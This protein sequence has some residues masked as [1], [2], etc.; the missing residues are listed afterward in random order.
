MDNAELMNLLPF[1]FQKIKDFI[2]LMETEETELNLLNL[3]RQRVYDNFFIQLAD[4]DTLTYHEK[5]LGISALNDETLEFR[6]LRVLNRYNKFQKLTLPELKERLNLILSVGNWE[7][8]ID[9]DKYEMNIEIKT[10]NL[11]VMKELLNTLI[12]TNPAHIQINAVQSMEELLSGNIYLGLVV[13]PSFHYIFSD[14]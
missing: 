8:S 3:N 12:Y 4:S 14:K 11:S 6:R 10:N 7:I 13:N 1:Y 2:A 5:L 9:Y